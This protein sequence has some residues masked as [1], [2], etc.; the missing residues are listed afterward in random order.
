MTMALAGA[1]APVAPPPGPNPDVAPAASD[2]HYLVD[3]PDAVGITTLQLPDRKVDVWYPSQ[4]AS[5]PTTKDDLANVLPAGLSTLSRPRSTS[6][7]TSTVIVMRRHRVVIIH[8]SC[9]PM[10]SSRGAISRRR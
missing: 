2:P 1:C 7:S 5:G 6:S 9:S 3:G 10:A 8:S 4:P